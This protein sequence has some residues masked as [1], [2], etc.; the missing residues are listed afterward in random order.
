MR[1]AGLLAVIVLAALLALTAWLGLREDKVPASP[2]DGDLVARGAY[3][4]R[5]GDCQACH[6]ARGGI[7]FA[8]GRAIRTPFGTIHAPNIT[9]DKETG[10]GRWSADDFW[11][12]LHNGKGRDGKLL[13]PAFPYPNYTRVTRADADALHAY[14]MSLQPVRQQNREPELRFPFNQRALLVVWRALYFRPGVYAEQPQQN[15]EWNRGA[16]LVQ[17]LGHCSACHTPRNALG[18]TS[19]GRELGGAMIPMLDWHAASLT[20][21]REAGLGNW[22]VQQLVDL[23]KTGISAR[24]VVSGPMSE[25]VR[26]STQHLEDADLRAM[27]VYLKSLPKA[28]VPARDAPPLDAESQRILKLGAALYEKH[29][30]DCHKAEGSGEPPHIPPLAGNHA[31][32]LDAP[33]NTIRA[34]MHGGYPPSTQG[35]PRPY[36]MPPFGNVLSDDEVAAVVSFVRNS[37]GN[38]ASMVSG[39]QANRYRTVQVD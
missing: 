30:A 20:G 33:V 25:V 28:D 1:K 24:G 34:V 13:Y 26:E 19:N 37:W 23:M 15:G 22:D 6:T 2:G 10:I 3:L 14:F 35:N 27:A 21:E 17:G 9:P 39:Q 12:A 32:M 5:A 18:A 11:N 29:C 36:G 16:Y 38:R 31:V 7:L 8:G 4:A